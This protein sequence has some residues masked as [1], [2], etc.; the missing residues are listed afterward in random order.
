MQQHVAILQVV[1]AEAQQADV[2]SRQAALQLIDLHKEVSLAR[3][4]R[5]WMMAVACLY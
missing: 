2:I 3:R 4:L 5:D 1:V